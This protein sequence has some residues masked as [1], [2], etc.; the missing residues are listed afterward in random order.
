M[1]LQTCFLFYSLLIGSAE[2]CN[3]FCFAQGWWINFHFGVNCSFK[4]Q[5][6]CLHTEVGHTNAHDLLY[7]CYIP[8][9]CP[10]CPALNFGKWSHSA[11]DICHRRWA[12]VYQHFGDAHPQVLP[13]VSWPGS[14]CWLGHTRWDSHC[15]IKHWVNNTNPHF[16]QIVVCF[17]H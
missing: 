16:Q 5:R 4:S 10:Q 14:P 6:T 1:S 15:R 12:C 9:Q 11:A 8:L 3:T 7:T 17:L 13:S 2:W